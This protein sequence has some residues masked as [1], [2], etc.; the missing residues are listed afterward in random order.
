MKS[1]Q[2]YEEVNVKKD[3]KKDERKLLITLQEKVIA[4]K[5]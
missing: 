4:K 5:I 2:G 1:L 3:L